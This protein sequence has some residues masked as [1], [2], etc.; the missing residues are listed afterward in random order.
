MNIGKIQ[1]LSEEHAELKIFHDSCCYEVAQLT[2][3]GGG[4]PTATLSSRTTK[5]IIITVRKAI[6]EE[7]DRIEMGIKAE[8]TYLRRE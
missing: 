6:L 4:V 7:L 8:A 1:M 2:V 5:R 3:D